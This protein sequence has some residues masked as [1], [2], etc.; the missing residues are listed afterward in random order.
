MKKSLVVL[1][2]FLSVIIFIAGSS[3][4]INSNNRLVFLEKENKELQMKLEQVNSISMLFQD[5]KDKQ[6]LVPKESQIYALPINGLK[7][8]NMIEPNTVIQVIDAAQCQNEQLWFYVSIPVYDSPINHKGWIPESET[9]K[10]TQDNVKQVQGDVYLKE[11]TPI[12][13]VEQFNELNSVALNKTPNDVRGRI[14]KREGSFVN[15]MAPGGW[16]FWVEDKYLIFP[17]VE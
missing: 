8:L 4:Q 17:K 15:L 6:R 16:Y 10:L 14:E 5:Y 9:V 13:E 1:F 2:I 7:K 12:Y 11:G 3:E